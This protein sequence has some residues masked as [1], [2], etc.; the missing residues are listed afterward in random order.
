M[1]DDF[2]MKLW[3]SPR[4]RQA[5]QVVAIGFVLVQLSFLVRPL[6]PA[7]TGLRADNFPWGM[8]KDASRDDKVV[9]AIGV[10]EDGQEVPIDLHRWFHY[11]RGT[12]NLRVYDHHP[13][14]MENKAWHRTEQRAFA[15][16][17]A[18]NVWLDDGIKLK[19]VRLERIRTRIDNKKVRIQPIVT[20]T[21]EPIDL[22]LEIP[23]EARVN[24]R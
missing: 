24:S 9:V 5:L 18:R 22:E 23:R 10:T 15:R 14:M 20:V 4:G 7:A 2:P 19:E 1:L 16:W 3:R 12:T 8:F 6:L 11:T 21:I 17:L 13:A